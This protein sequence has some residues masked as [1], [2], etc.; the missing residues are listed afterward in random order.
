VAQ[1]GTVPA[2]QE[3]VRQDPPLLIEMPGWRPIVRQVLTRAVLVS[4]LPMAVFYATLSLYGVRAAALVT[5]SLYYVGLLS[6]VIRRQPVLAAALLAAGLLAL[7]TIIVFLTGSA[8]IYFLQ[9]VAGTVAV[10]TA[11]AATALAGRP[12]LERLAHEFCPIAPELSDHLRSAQFFTWLSLVWTVT[13]GVNAVGTVWLLTTS[14]LHGFIMIKAFV[15]PLLTSTAGLIT[16]L[17]FRHTVRRRNLRISWA[18]HQG[19]AAAK[20]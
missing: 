13:Y 16:F 5:A 2:D 15:G 19:W 17:L 1:A 14:S 3:G 12:V 18:H 9:P 6:R 7:R 4:L 8:F 11:F 20:A 10:A